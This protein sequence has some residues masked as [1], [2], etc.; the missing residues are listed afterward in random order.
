MLR[1]DEGRAA[2]AFVLAMAIGLSLSSSLGIYS[3]SDL[4]NKLADIPKTF[5]E[6]L[7]IIETKTYNICHNV[8]WREIKA[9]GVKITETAFKGFLQL[10]ERLVLNLGS[11]RIYADVEARVMWV[12]SN[13]SNSG[14]DSDVC[15]VQFA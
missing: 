3:L 10:C 8:K 4:Q 9:M 1:A 12:Y 14:A 5:E 11:L 13:P 2:V 15:Y 6:G 7:Q